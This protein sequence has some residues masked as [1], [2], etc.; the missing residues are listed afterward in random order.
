M[1]SLIVKVASCNSDS[2]LKMVHRCPK[3]SLCWNEEREKRKQ[4]EMKRRDEIEGEER[5]YP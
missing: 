5:R 2:A 3:E 4:S 1:A